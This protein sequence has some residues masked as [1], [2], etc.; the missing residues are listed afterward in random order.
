MKTAGSNLAKSLI[1]GFKSKSSTFK[2]EVS[3]SCQTAASGASGARSSF[4]SAG[5]YMCAGLANGINSSSFLVISAATAVAKAAASAAKA[6]LKIA[7][8]SKVFY[9][10]GVYAGMGMVNALNDYSEKTYNA[11]YDVGDSAA[12]GLNRAVKRMGVD[13]FEGIDLN[14]KITPVL[15]LSDVKNGANT[16]DRMLSGITPMTAIGDISA[17][18]SSMARTNQNGSASDI[19]DELKALR[20]ELGNVSGDS[21][22]I[23]D[24]RYDDDSTVSNAVRDLIHATKVESRV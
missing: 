10:I 12:E 8:P 9:Q 24:V 18:S 2:S 7:S 3:R 15:D 5:V 14:P 4:Y 20:K 6:A 1:D 16:I 17:I 22:M 19:V 13:Y 21:Y 23:G 11:G